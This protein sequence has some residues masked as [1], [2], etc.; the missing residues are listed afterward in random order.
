MKSSR[1]ILIIA[2]VFVI[3]TFLFIFVQPAA[4]VDQS[5]ASVPSASPKA[6]VQNG[7]FTFDEV[8]E[9]EMV[10][11]EYV[12]ENQGGAPLEILDVRTTC[13][14]TTAQPPSAIA[15][16]SQDK[17]IVTANT[18]GYGGRV[19]NKSILVDTNDPVQKRIALNFYGKVAQLA[20]IEPPNFILKG[21]V[22]ESVQGKVTIQPNPKYPFHISS[23]GLDDRLTGKV[24]VQIDQREGGYDIKVLNLVAQPEIYQ[25]KIILKT[26]HPQRPELKVY[27]H[28]RI[29]DLKDEVRKNHGVGGHGGKE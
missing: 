15:P 11:H 21:R 7:V 10:T 13:G 5:P 1:I 12:I 24:D 19:F 22:G 26:D 8:L 14:C 17:I 23:F 9:G 29:L 25:G 28:A 2:S 6:V 27:L 20:R 18:K 3:H 16:H 4:A